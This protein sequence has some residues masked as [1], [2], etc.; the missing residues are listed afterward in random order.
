[1]VVVADQG[2][3]VRVYEGEVESLSVANTAGVGVRVVDGGRQGLAW[4]GTLDP[5]AVGA[6]LDEARDNLRFAS[7]DP[8]KP[9][10]SNPEDRVVCRSR[11][12]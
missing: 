3:E 5:D 9:T 2:T 6:L 10:G 12:K 11:C 8:E 1:V 7:S 4:A